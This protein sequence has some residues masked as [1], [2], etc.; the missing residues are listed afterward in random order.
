[1]KIV[2]VNRNNQF[3]RAF[4]RGKSYSFR[5]MIIFIIK[6]NLKINRIGIVASKKVGCA[7]ERN[8]TRR[9]V[10]NA[11]CEVSRFIISGY[12]LVFVIRS[13]AINYKVRD[14]RREL[15]FGAKQAKILAN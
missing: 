10:R 4:N 2:T 14:A 1:M 9:I 3:K 5:G 7:V 6:N 12:D 8:R 13:H 11:Y 15:F